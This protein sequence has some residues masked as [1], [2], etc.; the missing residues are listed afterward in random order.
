MDFL[1]A[2][3]DFSM[4]QWSQRE[5]SVNRSKAAGCARCS[6]F[7]RHVT[8]ASDKAGS[9]RPTTSNAL[10]YLRSMFANERLAGRQQE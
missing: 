9:S 5:S 10:S 1:L 7:E 2:L 3:F 4:T 6:S 8:E